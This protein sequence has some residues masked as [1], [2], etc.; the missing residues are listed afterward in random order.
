MPE[1]GQ[2]N[3]DPPPPGGSGI[4]FN[5]QHFKTPP[6]IIKIIQVVSLAWRLPAMAVT[7]T[8]DFFSVARMLAMFVAGPG[9]L[10]VKLKHAGIRVTRFWT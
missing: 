7:Q 3:V 10:V 6:G 8:R 2:T 5:P 1:A 9:V 4:R